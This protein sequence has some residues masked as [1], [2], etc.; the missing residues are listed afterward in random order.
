MYSMGNRERIVAELRIASRPL[1]DDELAR[2][3]GI[4]P[5]QTVNGICRD[6]EKAGVLRRR[7]GP[8]GKLVNELV[9]D[10]E[11]R[12]EGHPHDPG[13]APVSGPGTGEA[14]VRRAPDEPPPGHSIEQQA[15]ERTM[16]D[17]LGQQ[18]GTRLDPARITVPGGAQVEIDGA[19]DART[20]LVECW[21]HLGPPR[22]AQRHKVLANALKLVWISRAL[23]PV[24]RLILCM[25]DPLAAA[26]FL[27]D[28]RS[29]AA[30]ALHDLGIGIRLVDLP[31]SVRQELL[32]AQ[33]RQYR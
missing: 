13:Q 30:H 16:L 3:A 2:R 8:D 23:S 29:W 14:V 28:G 18:L 5:R 26:P 11:T 25:A 22:S 17:L 27:P 1:D 32:S 10:P 21:A 19:D 12:E 31:A 6:L 7:S 15:A 33:R 20:V 24:P 9:R 4:S